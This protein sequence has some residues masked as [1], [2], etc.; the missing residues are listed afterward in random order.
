M[1]NMNISF[2]AGRKPIPNNDYLLS[3]IKLHG[4]AKYMSA[5][6]DFKSFLTIDDSGKVDIMEVIDLNM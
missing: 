6:N 3:C 2:W 1:E 5:S 4:K